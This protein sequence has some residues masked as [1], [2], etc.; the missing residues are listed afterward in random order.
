[1][2]FCLT[3][4]LI[5]QR[6]STKLTG[7]WSVLSAKMVTLSTLPTMNALQLQPVTKLVLVLINS[8][9]ILIELKK[10]FALLAPLEHK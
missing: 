1:M 2:L 5:A 7:L 9:L 10:I 3:A 8:L 4:T 6:W